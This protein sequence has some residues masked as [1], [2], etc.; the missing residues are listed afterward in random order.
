MVMNSFENRNSMQS[1]CLDLFFFEVLGG[2]C[3][4]GRIYSIFPLFPTCSLYVPFNFSM[5]SHQVPNVFPIASRFNPICFAQSPP[6]SHLYR[7]AKGSVT[8]PVYRIFYFGGGSVVSTFFCNGP[9]KLTQCQ[10]KMKIGLIRQLQLININH[11]I[12][13]L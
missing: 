12:I 3:G 10:K 8:P 4:V 2:G 6:P 9:I 11:T 5:G 1:R 13:T 7:W